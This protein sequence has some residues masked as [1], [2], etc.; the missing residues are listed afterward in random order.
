MWSLVVRK[1]TIGLG[2]SLWSLG[3]L[4]N[5]EEKFEHCLACLEARIDAKMAP[6]R[7][8]VA[9]VEGRVT[10]KVMMKFNDEYKWEMNEE[11]EHTLW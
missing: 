2:W 10:D 8:D 1:C 6:S 4:T 7:T 3:E 11:D 5:L 9:A